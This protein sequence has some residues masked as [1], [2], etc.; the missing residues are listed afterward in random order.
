M[1]MQC[2]SIG[3]QA[4]NSAS[5]SSAASN[6]AGPQALPL[7]PNFPELTVHKAPET[8]GGKNFPA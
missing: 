8:G 3:L 7:C 4:E 1:L 6:A 2:W 5:S